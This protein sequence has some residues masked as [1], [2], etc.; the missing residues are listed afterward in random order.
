VIVRSSS[1]ATFKE[2]PAKAH[3]MYELG[4]VRP[5]RK[6]ID[7]LFGSIVH[8]AIDMFNKTGDL[9]DAFSLIESVEWPPSNKKTPAL[10]KL[11]VRLYAKRQQGAQK[12]FSERDFKFFLGSHEWRG[13]W[14]GLTIMQEGIFIDELKTTN[15]RF[16]I[17]KPNDQF[18]SYY[19][20]ARERFGDQV[21]GIYLYDFDVQRADIKQEV[22]RFTD[23][24]VEIWE[25][26]ALLDIDYFER[27]KKADIWPKRASSC[28]LYGLDYPCAYIPICQ[29]PATAEMLTRKMFTISEEARTLSW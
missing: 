24:E 29:S 10:A 21:K 15:W 16:F 28:L 12:I 27:C 11:F 9:Q 25:K 26:E 7:L 5:G 1:F 17:P 19:K 4:L 20:A 6:S 14:D 18:I 8:D 22:I 13:R 3:F 2:C 23:A